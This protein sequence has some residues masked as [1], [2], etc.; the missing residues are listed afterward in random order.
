M[1]ESSDLS[2][3]FLVWLVCFGLGDFVV[4]A[5]DALQVLVPAGSLQIFITQRMT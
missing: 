5:A 4:V 1:S 3:G 2:A